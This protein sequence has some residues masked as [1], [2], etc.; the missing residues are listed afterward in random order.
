MK[1]LLVDNASDTFTELQQVVSAAGHTVTSITHKE[2][3]LYSAEDYDVAV[4]SGGWWYDDETE[5]LVQYAEELEFIRVCPIP[6]LGI[7]IGMQLMHVALDRAVPL[8]DEPQSGLKDITVT[9]AG[10]RQGLPPKLRVH[11]N[12]TRG[13]LKADPIFDVL[14]TSPGHIE[15]MQH[16][17]RPMLGVQFH[18]EVGNVDECVRMLG[19]LL[20]L[21]I[22]ETNEQK[23]GKL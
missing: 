4:L 22:Y 2:I 19:M 13:I 3:P 18:P 17:E 11:K 10:I 5:L 20:G 16:R 7:C 1:I 15:I 6:L 14:A 8:L 9:E 12:H 21:I 23:E